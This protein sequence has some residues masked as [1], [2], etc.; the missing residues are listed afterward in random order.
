LNKPKLLLNS[1][2]WFWR[3]NPNLNET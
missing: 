1:E 3:L 2:T